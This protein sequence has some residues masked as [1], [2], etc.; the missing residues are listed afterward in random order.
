[1]PNVPP[2]TASRPGTLPVSQHEGRTLGTTTRVRVTDDGTTKAADARRGH[3]IEGMRERAAL[4]GGT[5]LAGP[6]PDAPAGWL[7]EATLERP[8]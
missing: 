5:L 3:G 6:D 7:V 8:R 1:M 4:H 2:M